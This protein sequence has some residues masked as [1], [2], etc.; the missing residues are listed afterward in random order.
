MHETISTLRL[1]KC[2]ETL[3]PSGT[4]S[5]AGKNNYRFELNMIDAR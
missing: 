5:L 3:A 2:P 4:I 1:I